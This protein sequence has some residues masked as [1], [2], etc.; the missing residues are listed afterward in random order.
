[1]PRTVLSA[2]ARFLGARA[3]GAGDSSCP[4]ADGPS[5]ATQPWQTLLRDALARAQEKG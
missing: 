5:D 3:L 4:G 2:L 1:M